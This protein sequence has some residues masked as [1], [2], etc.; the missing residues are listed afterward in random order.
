MEIKFILCVKD[1][2]PFV[3]YKF[4]SWEIMTE[5]HMSD[6]NRASW[7]RANKWHPY[8]GS[9]SLIPHETMKEIE[10]FEKSIGYAIQRPLSFGDEEVVIGMIN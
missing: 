7:S 5:E 4:W 1:D 2:V 9:S 6:R 8:C 3:P 10:R